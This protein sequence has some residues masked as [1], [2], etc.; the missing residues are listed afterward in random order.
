MRWLELVTEQP[1]A[2][3]R[4]RSLGFDTHEPVYHGTRAGQFPAFVLKHRP[5]EQLGFGIHVT[6]DRSFAERYAFDPLI[7]RKGKDPHLFVG[8]LRKGRVLDATAIVRDGTPEFALA[9]KLAGRKL[10]TQSDADGVACAYMQAAIDSTSGRRAEALI[11]AAGYDTIRY[12]STIRQ[13]A[14]GGSYNQGEAISYVVLN[15]SALRRQTAAFDPAKADS[16]DLE[17]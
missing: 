1:E 3:D 16:H 8:Y 14:V 2:L 4:A 17:A 10:M 11:R 9:Q 15:P 7:N 6:P 12:R 5:N 13:R